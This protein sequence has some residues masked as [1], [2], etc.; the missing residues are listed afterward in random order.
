MLHVYVKFS[1]SQKIV[2]ISDFDKYVFLN[3][4]NG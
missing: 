4:I 3:L 1:M 2:G